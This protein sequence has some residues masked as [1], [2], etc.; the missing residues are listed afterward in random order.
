MAKNKKDTYD[1]SNV[2]AL[3][4]MEAVRVRPGMYI[5]SDKNPTPLVNEILDNANDEAMNG[6]ASKIIIERKG[7]WI[8]VIDNGR[9]IPIGS[10]RDLEK[11]KLIPV[12]VILATTPHSG[13]KFDS[14]AYSISSGLHGIG[15]MAVNALS[16]K[17]R[18]DVYRYQQGEKRLKD[19]YFHFVC[20]FENQVLV[21]SQTTIV[22]KRPYGTKVSFVPDPKVFTSVDLDMDYLRR[23]VEFLSAWLGKV[24]YV[25][26]EEGKEPEV[27]K[28]DV[29]DFFKKY[30]EKS[31]ERLIEPIRIDFLDK[32]THRKLEVMLTICDDV[33][34][35]T[36]G[37]VNLLVTPTGSHVNS[38][39]NSVAGVLAELGKKR[40]IPIE[41]ED[42]KIGVR[43][44]ISLFLPEN[45]LS[46][47]GQTK[48]KLETDSK[49]FADLLAQFEVE[50][51][52]VLESHEKLDDLL[53]RIKAYRTKLKH[54]DVFKIKKGRGLTAVDDI[55][56]DCE[57][58]AG[59]LFLVEGLSACG[60][61]LSAR[62]YKKH[63]VMPLKGKSMN[64]VKSTHEAML[65]NKEFSNLIK[66]LGLGVR[67]S[68]DDPLDLSGL[69]YSKVIIGCDAD[70][71]GQHITA[72]LLGFFV[73]YYPELI[74]QG[75][76]YV[77]EAPLYKI[78]TKKKIFPA[79]SWA[80]VQKISAQYPNSAI[81]RYKGLGEMNPDAIY[82]YLLDPSIRKLIKIE[83]DPDNQK[84]KKL[85]DLFKLPAEKKSLLYD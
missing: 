34:K 37:A 32:K 13:G 15:L 33:K 48:E 64:V 46:F 17:M 31:T 55:L 79:W 42:A 82:A 45:I 65:K 41:R 80:E 70:D 77:V 43:V 16:T 8:A 51:T 12:P 61:I 73:S 22:D 47:A 40:K 63:A 68:P 67:H 24:E 14:F 30:V 60:S 4:P 62:D 49:H 11:K 27:I 25:F 39:L 28:M 35:V 83:L 19:Q 56:T 3:K 54:S 21:K 66:A 74:Q 36:Y 5:G 18:I 84:I 71:D 6:F 29:N 10:K 23:R 59:E 20:E 58:D 76:I 9:G 26:E 52:K 7:E 50:L 44:L 69:K 1:E 72:L 75:F 85:L 57:S 81:Q 53:A 78:T 38:I 2:R